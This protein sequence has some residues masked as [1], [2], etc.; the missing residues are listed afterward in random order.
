MKLNK[1]TRIAV[2]TVSALTLA[3]C[4]HNKRSNQYAVNDANNAYRHG[5]YAQGLGHESGFGE[6][7]GRMASSKNMYYFDFDSYQVR[8]ADKPAILAKANDLVTNP[9]KKM[10]L[11]GHTD[12]R[13]SREYNVG[14][15]ERRARSVASLMTSKGVKPSQLVLVS[16]GSEKPASSG[17]S[18]ADFQQDRRAA[19]VT[20]QN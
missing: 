8:D 10:M 3:A 15:G 7:G 1:W 16:Y 6:E 20:S 2:L 19:L 14:L 5:A 18:E 9:G 17:R 11:E 13:G 4:A 12:P